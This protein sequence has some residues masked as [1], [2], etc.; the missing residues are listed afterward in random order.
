LV[1]NVSYPMVMKN[2]GRQDTRKMFFFLS[3]ILNRKV[4]DSQGNVVGKIVDLRAK[5]RELFPPVIS[6]RVRRK[7]DRKIVAFLW[8]AVDSINDDAIRFKTSR[9]WIR[10]GPRLKG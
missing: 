1:W 8:K 2:D 6:V 3:E 7:K 4:I 5:L 10:T 9:S